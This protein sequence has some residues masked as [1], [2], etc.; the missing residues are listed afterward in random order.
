MC[1]LTTEKQCE[2]RLAQS[3]ILEVQQQSQRCPQQ[4]RD[5]KNLSG[6]REFCEAAASCVT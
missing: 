5:W 4:S 3:E 6:D 1:R 2:V